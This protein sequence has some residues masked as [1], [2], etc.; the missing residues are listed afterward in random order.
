MTMLILDANER[1]LGDEL[2]ADE[3]FKRNLART[4]QSLT[5][6]PD[7]GVQITAPLRCGLGDLYG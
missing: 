4:S 1:F 2:A 7:Q 6:N 3:A 5:H